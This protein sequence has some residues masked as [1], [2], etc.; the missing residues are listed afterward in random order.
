MLQEIQ[1]DYACCGFGSVQGCRT[2]RNIVTS[3]Y[4]SESIGESSTCGKVV[5]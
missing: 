3:D 4:D 1:Q 2:D 5:N